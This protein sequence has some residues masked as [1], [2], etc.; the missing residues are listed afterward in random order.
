[1][2]NLDT[3]TFNAFKVLLMVVI[4]VFVFLAHI[5]VRTL[6]LKKSYQIGDLKKD[7][8][9][10]ESEIANLTVEKNTL[11]S[12]SSLEKLTERFQAKGHVFRSPESH[13]LI[14]VKSKDTGKETLGEN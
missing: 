12:S 2:K 14:Y 1:M 7:L 5:W 6:I 10:V 8:V 9:G 11:L 4:C 13:Q 3:K